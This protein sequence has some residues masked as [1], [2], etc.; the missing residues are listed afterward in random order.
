MDPQPEGV[1]KKPKRRAVIYLLLALFVAALGLA[2]PLYNKF[3][4]PEAVYLDMPE[5]VSRINYVEPKIIKLTVCLKLHDSKSLN[6]AKKLM[7]E[8]QNAFLLLLSGLDSRDLDSPNFLPVLK[9]HL[10]RRAES[11]MEEKVQDVLIKS[12]SLN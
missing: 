11:I 10:Q 1:P 12:I 8:I 6:K 2:W 9:Q 7:P 3:K 4:K 5:V